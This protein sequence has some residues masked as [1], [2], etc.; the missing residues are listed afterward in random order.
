MII[1]C[2][3][4]FIQDKIHFQTILEFNSYFQDNLLL[5]VIYDIT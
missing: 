1:S 4:C 3:N 5:L 2:V